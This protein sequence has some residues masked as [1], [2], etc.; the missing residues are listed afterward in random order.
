MFTAEN[1]SPAYDK[2]NNFAVTHRLV[3]IEGN[4]PCGSR[5]AAGN[6]RL[7]EPNDIENMERTLTRE[8]KQQVGKTV[9]IAGWMH[10]LRQLS[11]VNFLLL[12]DASGI[13]QVVVDAKPDMQLLGSLHLESVLEVE[14]EVVAEKNAP[15]GVEIHN[16]RIR[17]ISEVKE[18]VPFPIN[19]GALNVNIDTFLDH[20]YF[21]LRH[22]DRRNIFK[23]SAAVMRGF[24]NHLESEGFIEITTPKIV[25]SATEGGANVFALDYFDRKAYLAQSPQFY[26]QIMVG[27]FERVFEVAPVF[28]A[29][30]HSTT[31]HLNEYVS[32]DVELG[33]IKDHTTVMQ[34]L[35]RLIRAMQQHLEQTMAP[36]LAALQVQLPMA[37]E[38]FPAISFVEA[39]NLIAE[40]YGED[41]RHEPDLSPQHERW[42]CE[43]ARQEH[44]SDYLF[45]T[46]F[47]MSKRP[48]YTHPNPSDKK[49]ANGFDLLFRGLELVTGGQRLHLYEDYVEVLKERGLPLEPFAGYL[50]AFRFGMPPH[51][52]FAIGL[53]R[54][55]MQLLGLTNVREA[56]LFP[57]DVNRLSP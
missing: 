5:S 25:A 20:A 13:A 19:K 52:G 33:F 3:Q 24:R 55:L 22:P 44:N 35:N 27:I 9:R 10:S 37:P 21:G 56:T 30:P 41:C 50:D 15:E 18:L 11:K 14:G 47:P 57:R 34:V 28:R 23:L 51:G 12:R 16:P 8:L 49:Y 4:H 29:E 48:F 36:E 2:I 42:L 43:W 53:E 7:P 1:H 32:L 38:H 54:F 6:G 26:K 31:R 17:V 39:Q 45:V 40:R 46:G